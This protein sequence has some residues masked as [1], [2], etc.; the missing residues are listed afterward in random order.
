MDDLASGA[1]RAANDFGVE[2][3]KLESS[4]A[5]F[6]EDIRAMSADYDLVVTTF[7]YM[8]DPTILVSQEFPDTKYAAIFQFINL[9]GTSYQNIWDTEFHGEG[10][11]YLCGYMAGKATQTNR[12]GIL[13]G[14]E[15]PSPNAEG[16]AFMQGAKAA[17]PDITV[18]FCL[19]RKL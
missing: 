16:N 17:N 12:V 7:P 1:E 4:Q 6:E 3:K 9:D 19:C 15:E 2:I 13:I 18:D 8:T 11:F 14:G 10:A 5:S